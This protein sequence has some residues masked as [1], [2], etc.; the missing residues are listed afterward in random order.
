MSANFLFKSKMP[1]LI[2]LFLISLAI[3]PTFTKDEKTCVST[4][5]ELLTLHYQ[6]LLD[7]DDWYYNADNE[8]WSVS[9][10]KLVKHQHQATEVNQNEFFFPPEQC[11]PLNYLCFTCSCPYPDQIILGRLVPDSTTGGLTQQWACYSFCPNCGIKCRQWDGF[12]GLCKRSKITYKPLCR[13]PECWFTSLPVPPIGVDQFLTVGPRGW[14][15]VQT[16][17]PIFSCPGACSNFDVPLCMRKGPIHPYGRR[18]I[19]RNDA[20]DCNV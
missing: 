4:S 3:L 16:V 2:Q 9:T 17:D 5:P 8:E 11:D 20:L 19:C 13:V 12:L 6:Q 18:R 14:S 10:E 7:N 1:L 15:V